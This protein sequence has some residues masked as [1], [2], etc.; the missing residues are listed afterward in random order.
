MG[1]TQ[2]HRNY[3]NAR[4]DSPSGGSTVD[5]GGIRPVK[6]D[7]TTNLDE[8]YKQAF[9]HGDNSLLPWKAAPDAN[10]KSICT[11]VYDDLQQANDKFFPDSVGKAGAYFH[12]SRISGDGYRVQAR[13]CFEQF[14]GGASQFPNQA[15]LKRRYPVLPKADTSGLRV[16][17]KTSFR[18]YVCW[19]PAALTHWPAKAAPTAEFYRAAHLHYVHENANP[20]TP[21]AAF[22]L[23][24]LGDANAL[25]SQN[26]YR[27][28]VRRTCLAPYR[29]KTITLNM[30][31]V[32]PFLTE[33]RYAVPRSGLHPKTNGQAELCPISRICS[34][35]SMTMC[36][37]A[38]ST[39]RGAGTG[40]N[41]FIW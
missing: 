35:S 19:A 2:N 6:N 13:Y 36:S 4:A 25:V 18:G 12:P 41:C 1:D 10:T 32:W 37:T 24:P 21:R 30:E 38:C 5:M 40:M 7:G 29:T 28:I 11:I 15:V 22:P 20:T 33:R 17:R 31:Y 3:R 23:G 34:I 8:Y 39:A 16:W 26:E 9:G 14:P 27:D